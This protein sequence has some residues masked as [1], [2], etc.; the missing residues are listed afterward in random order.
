[1]RPGI[2]SLRTARFAR[3]FRSTLTR[4]CERGSF[5]VVH[6]SIQR[7]HVHLIVEAAGKKALASGMKS[8]GPRLARAVQ[9]VFA[10]RGRVLAGRYH[11]HVLNSPRE[12]RNALAYVLLNARKHWVQRGRR[13][14]AVRLD[15]CSSARWFD[16]WRTKPAADSDEGAMEVARPR[17]WLLVKGWRRHRLIDPAEVPAARRLGVK[18]PDVVHAQRRRG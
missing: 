9:A 6:Y 8:V 4:G 18:F 12:V 10:V 17:S 15:A 1:V 2:P 5:R 3:A 16:G 7:D 14:P 11:L 13:M